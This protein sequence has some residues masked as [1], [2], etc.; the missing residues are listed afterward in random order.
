[1]AFTE[2][3]NDIF[4]SYGQ[5]DDRLDGWVTAFIDALEGKLQI[6]VGSGEGQIKFWRDRTHLPESSSITPHIEQVLKNSALFV[7]VLSPRYMTSKSC[8]SEIEAFCKSHSDA[9]ERI[10]IAECYP[11]DELLAELDKDEDR[12]AIRERAPALFNRKVRPFWSM[13]ENN[14]PERYPIPGREKMREENG[15][16]VRSLNEFGWQIKAKLRKL[17]KKPPLVKP[18]SNYDG[19]AVLVA[20]GVND[21]MADRRKE[22]RS[23]LDQQGIR[24]LPENSYSLGAESFN[25]QIKQDLA[26]SALFVQLLGSR[27]GEQPPDMP[28]GFGCRQLEAAREN[29]VPI[30][31]WRA[32]ELSPTS[33]DSKFQEQL[34][35]SADVQAAPFTDFMQSVKDALAPKSPSP[36]QED[37]F[38]FINVSEDDIEYAKQIKDALGEY[39]CLI[40]KFDPSISADAREQVFRDS[41]LQCKGL[42]VVYGQAKPEWVLRQIKQ[43]Q[44]LKSGSPTASPAIWRAPPEPKPVD[45]TIS[46]FPKERDIDGTAFK[47]AIVKLRAFLSQ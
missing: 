46:G 18:P 42:V 36:K 12:D 7:C 25:S 20:V 8:L 3:E 10:F 45:M 13:N 41:A 39:D 4:I 9:D 47:E 21:D 28:Q 6:L 37:G 2:Y 23:F 26:K 34:L 29:K 11:R 14:H 43:F 22:L 1:M 38:V 16:F 30:L 31:Q 35:G 5:V 40:P 15:P 44:K 33:A 17:A 27:T 32:P 24:V 19:R